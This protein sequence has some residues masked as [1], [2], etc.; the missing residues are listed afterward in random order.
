MNG[1]PERSS[2]LCQAVFDTPSKHDLLQ[3][4]SEQQGRAF[5]QEGQQWATFPGAED[6][7]EPSVCAS[8]DLQSRFHSHS[9]ERVPGFVNFSTS[10]GCF[11]AQYICEWL[12]GPHGGLD[13]L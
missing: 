1:F 6:E 7:R 11:L 5:L 3:Q 2:S 13:R 10:L 4:R 9:G 12:S 8:K